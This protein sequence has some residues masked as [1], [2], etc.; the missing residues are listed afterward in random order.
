MVGEISPDGNFVW[1]GVEWKPNPEKTVEEIQV[2]DIANNH[3]ESGIQED[4][5][6]SNWQPVPEKTEDGGKG[7]LIAM[8]IVGLLILTALSWIVYAFVIDPMLFPEPYNKEKFFSVIDDQPTEDEVMSGELGSWTCNI[9]LE[10]EEDGMK[11]RT[12][13]DIYVSKDSAR[14][15][16]KISAGIFG[17]SSTDVWVDNSEIV[18]KS[19]D[20]EGAE[21]NKVKISSLESSPADELIANSSTELEMCFLHHDIVESMKN[22]PEQKFSS[23]KERF[24][25]EEGERAVK[26]ETR[27]EI[28]GEDGEMKIAVY[29]DDDEN[30]LGTRITNSTF[31]CVITSGLKSFSKP[32]WAGITPNAPMLL[33]LEEDFIFGEVHSSAVKT[34]YNATYEFIGS[35]Q[36][37][38]IFEE[39][40]DYENDIENNTIIHEVSLEDA[41]NEGVTIQVLNSYDEDVNCTINYT[42]VDSDSSI[43]PGDTVSITCEESVMNGYKIGIA[44]GNGIAHQVDMQ[45]PWISP[46]FTIIALLGAAVLVSRRD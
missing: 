3:E 14:S 11:I 19:E 29:F 42:D 25:D 28:D 36:T 1:D 22:N 38:V 8:S 23:E 5:L 35:E 9:E 16:S 27:M 45:V 21:V 41:M 34:Q 6:D 7:K 4:N 37:I 26:V 33:E 46:I 20:V 43:S 31:E 30:I 15:Y 12:Y 32:V 39:D 13:F 10:M 24:P 40:Y 2:N 17:W 18:W 44:D